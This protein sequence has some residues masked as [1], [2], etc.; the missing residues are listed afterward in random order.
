MTYLYILFISSTVLVGWLGC[1]SGHLMNIMNNQIKCQLG[2][3]GEET[4]DLL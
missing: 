2:S 1:V 4:K 3:Y